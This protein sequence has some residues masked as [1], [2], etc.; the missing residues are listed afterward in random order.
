MFRIIALN[1]GRPGGA[2][3][4][5]E[6]S[7]AT[8]VGLQRSTKAGLVGP[9][10]PLCRRPWR[11]TATA[12]NEGR[13]GGAGNPPP[14][15]PANP[16]AMSPLNEGRPG[17]A[18]NPSSGPNDSSLRSLYAQ[19]RPAWWGRQPLRKHP[20]CCLIAQRSTKAGLVGPATLADIYRHSTG[21]TAQRRPAWWGRQPLHR[22]RRPPFP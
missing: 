13:P 8:G 22:R 4:P 5:H 2:G 16:P 6:L 20:D 9:A 11:A 1:E 17:G 7:L 3:N 10:T 18:G 21:S 19:R 14:A 15:S 12:L